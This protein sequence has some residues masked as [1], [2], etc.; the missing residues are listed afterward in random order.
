MRKILLIVALAASFAL[1]YAMNEWK[2]AD[3]PAPA[4]VTGLGGIFFKCK[5]VKAQKEWYQ[6]NLGLR[7]D[8][9]GTLFEWRLSDDSSKI[10]TTQW[11]VFKE[12]TK[13]FAPSTKEFMINYRVNDLERLVRQLK[14]AKVTIVDTMEV[15]EYGKFIHILD[16]EGNK[17][18]LWEPIEWKFDKTG[19]GITK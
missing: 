7:M 10:G 4:R 1:G 6:K 14:T 17:I 8:Q 9:Y 11:S 16:P 19:R 5:D 12:T 15:V 13:Y 2:K 18:E 3:Q